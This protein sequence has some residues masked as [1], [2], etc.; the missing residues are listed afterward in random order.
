MTIADAIS[1]KPSH[2]K[3][4]LVIA[5][6]NGGRLLIDG[7]E[8][9]FALDYPSHRREVVVVDDGS[10]DGS[11]DAVK[12]VFAGRLRSSELRVIRNELPTGVP[13][14]YNRGIRETSPDSIY[15][16]KLDN[17]VVVRS[18]SLSALV[19][20]A[21]ANPT[22]GVF[23]GTVYYRS[24]PN[25][26]QFVGGNLT[27]PIRGPAKLS[28]PPGFRAPEE[29]D[30]PVTVDV[31]NSCMALIRRRVF[32][33]VGL[34]P[35]DY[36]LY[37]Y[38]D[39][40]FAFRARKHGFASMYCPHAV[41]YHEVSATSK[42]STLSLVRA[43]LRVRNGLLFMWRFAPK[44]WRLS[45]VVYNLAKLPADVVRGRIP[46]S[47]AVVG[48]IDG[49]RAVCGPAPSRELLPSLSPSSDD[50]DGPDS[51]GALMPSG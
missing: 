39:Y 23:G 2:P 1:T 42:D 7:L 26:V 16:L 48:W 8:S 33:V 28:F 49:L 51:E 34:F 44:S 41:A 43:R 46:L 9:V 4:S 47:T 21:E 31:V 38:E 40:D 20:C 30:A 25:R 50:L 14:A 19:R 27:S 29:M 13:S 35:E 45:Y 3:V 15:V 10:D 37:E 22:A 17:D 32:E 36:G 6:L 5:S 12:S 11:V 18:D 24:D